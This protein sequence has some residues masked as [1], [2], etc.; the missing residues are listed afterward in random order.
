MPNK[1]DDF[2]IVREVNQRGKAFILEINIDK[3]KAAFD[4]LKANDPLYCNQVWDT[5]L[6]DDIRRNGGLV[7]EAMEEVDMTEERNA[8]VEDQENL[9]AQNTATNEEEPNA[10]SNT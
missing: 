5:D 1:L 2:K 6:E 9:D 4:W 3:V 7:K 10:N 8:Q